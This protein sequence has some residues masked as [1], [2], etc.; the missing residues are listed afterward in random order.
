MYHIPVFDKVISS[1]MS[2]NRYVKLDKIQVC[3]LYKALA[4]YGLGLIGASEFN[5]LTAIPV[6]VEVKTKG[7]GKQRV[8]KNK[9]ILT[10]SER[11]RMRYVVQTSVD[12]ILSFRGFIYYMIQN[13]LT[14]IKREDNLKIYKLAKRFQFHYHNLWVLPFMNEYGILNDE[15]IEKIKNYP[16]A[17]TPRIAEKILVEN[18]YKLKSYIQQYAYRKLR[19]IC[20]SNN[21]TLEDMCGPLEYIACHSCYN[22]IAMKRDLY[23]INSMKQ[24][25]HN[26]AIN[27]IMFYTSD[28]RKR[29]SALE[30]TNT[31][32][33]QINYG[34]G[35]GSTQFFNREF[36]NKIISTTSIGDD[37]EEGDLLEFKYGEDSSG[38]IE[39][40]AS[41]F[42]IHK[43]IQEDFGKNSV[44]ERLA[45]ILGNSSLPFV[46]W[47]NLTKRPD[48]DHSSVASIQECEGE[49]FIK[50]MSDYFR[51]DLPKFQ[52]LLLD[53]KPLYQEI[54]SAE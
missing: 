10:G 17:V 11:V 22:T 54:L 1:S 43:R 51:M 48:R 34:L 24:S 41:L 18:F 15:F 53:F 25:I 12:V 42:F 44:Q 37:G 23:L 32:A 35:R 33:S 26:E 14:K 19:F 21:M 2:P 46:N 49:N 28:R 47:Y 36:Q 50:V 9:D 16:P 7:G 39:Q 31:G 3:Q 6:W 20:D 52:Q 4:L 29:L 30:Q 13:N 40:K 38:E 45:A 8:L 5:N 27:M